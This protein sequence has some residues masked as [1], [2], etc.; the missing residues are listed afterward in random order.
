M[1]C[2]ACK[3]TLTKIIKASVQ[4]LACE[5]ECGGLWFSQSQVNKL[6]KLNSGLGMS[7]LKIK[8]AD[9]IKV[10]RG[11][12]HI[13]STVQNHIAVQTL[14]Q[15][16]I[17]YRSQSVRQVWWILDRCRGSFKVTI[18]EWTAKTKSCKKIFLRYSS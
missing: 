4:V 18:Y 16:G 11:A 13:L 17:G 9:G 10:Y 15:Q 1:E 5:D 12:E 8:R 2:P 6:K 14:F 7:L 3:N